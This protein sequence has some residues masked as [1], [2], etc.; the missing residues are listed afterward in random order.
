MAEREVTSSV[1][2]P[3]AIVGMH[4]SG[5]SMLAHLL[6]ACGVDLGPEDELLAANEFNRDGYWENR[7]VVAL[8]DQ[9]LEFFGGSWDAP[10][11]APSP[12]LVDGAVEQ[13]G[14]S[15]LEV[16]ERLRTSAV[17]GWKDPRTTLTVAFWRRLL[18]DLRLVA[19]LRDPVEVALSLQRRGATSPT[20][21]LRL[22]LEYNA[23]VAA[24]VDEGD[25]VISAYDAFFRDPETELRRVLTGLGLPVSADAVR[26]ATEHVDPR[27][28]H[29]AA[30]LDDAEA[31]ITLPE[32]VATLYTA[33]RAYADGQEDGPPVVAPKRSADAGDRPVV[34][35][36]R[37]FAAVQSRDR[38]LR[39][40]QDL[41]A[42]RDRW[43]AEAERLRSERDKARSAIAQATQERDE[44]RRGLR[45][46]GR[47]RD[48]ARAE[49]LALAQARDA[50]R[51]E[52]D[53][54][55]HEAAQ[56]AAELEDAV[57]TRDELRVELHRLAGRDEARETELTRLLA[58]RDADRAER[59]ADR[60]ERERLQEQL[61]QERA[62]QD[63]LRAAQAEERVRAVELTAALRE[64]EDE[65]ARL[66]EVHAAELDAVRHEGR[67]EAERLRRAR[68][69][70]RANVDRLRR[71]RDAALA[72]KA[73]LE[74]ERERLSARAHQLARER[75]A[76]HARAEK[77][78]AQARRLREADARR[79]TNR[80]RRA[81]PR[82]VLAKLTG[83]QPVVR[84]G[85]PSRAL[86][87]S[88]AAARDARSGSDA[89]PSSPVRGGRPR[90]A[91]A[92]KATV[93]VVIPTRNAGP[94]FAR[95]LAAIRAQ[96]GV[97]SL[98]LVVVDSGSTDRTLELAERAGARIVQI[99]PHE[100]GHGR[101]RNLGVQ[102]ATGELLVMMV[103]DA[104]L[105]GR[106]ALRV[107]RD[108]LDVD[109]RL[110]G[111]SARQ[112]ART[113]ADLF[114]AF[115]VWAHWH[116]ITRARASVGPGR[117]DLDALDPVQRRALAP[118]DDVCCM[119]RRSM[120]EQFGYA[121]VE[122]AEDLELGLRAVRAGWDLELLDAVSVAHS[123]T[124]DSVYHLRR[125][126]ADRLRVAP[127]IGDHARCS[128]SDADVEEVLA[129]A[130]V[131][132]T[133]VAGVCSDAFRAHD[134][135][136][137]AAERVRAGLRAG[138]AP[139][140]EPNPEAR[141][142]EAFIAEHASATVDRDLVQAL[143]DELAGT[144]S[145]RPLMTYGATCRHVAKDDAAAFMAKLSGAVI[146][147]VV[148]DSLRRDS[149][150]PSRAW[151]LNG[152]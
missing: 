98:E 101:T 79:L 76:M 95:V 36:S 9:L 12:E 40:A 105:L 147:R 106:G 43:R 123:H 103:Q 135:L 117:V 99:A 116:T 47:E 115:G 132:V 13:F 64:A 142:L 72:E 27:L 100:F 96:D 80:L 2:V 122:F 120:W 138:G 84:D 30:Q 6:A 71:E 53:D 143:R 68:D 33:L 140:G 21:A 66:K 145:W 137:A 129:A 73:K 29:H 74:R 26:R 48:E 49:L 4:R 126:V 18:P 151:L 78:I 97:G 152:V 65:V 149:T 37:E 90:F 113:D 15:A 85:S 139:L 51:D 31:P 111:V 45:D 82:R 127:L 55:R 146:G 133:E 94:E 88:A 144:L 130:R 44:A 28:R 148:G 52:I 121:D 69:A 67:A 136:A 41:R 7:Y 150:Q 50:L 11:S 118:L 110:G 119:M 59:E 124:R 46:V 60:A 56:R 20:L 91:R 19:A 70:E 125:S 114:G 81:T 35:A 10:P 17:W 38:W 57:R 42:D 23:R 54:L 61:R 39:E 93:S 5:T 34:A 62:R 83:R 32:E 102:T 24:L 22:W 108:R 134:S 58:D 63:E 109:E 112:V 89:E 16:L 3:I 104:F 8:N 128:A 1:S 131:V 25:V 92:G 141:R 14:A 107:M 86:P 75:D 77:W 87:S